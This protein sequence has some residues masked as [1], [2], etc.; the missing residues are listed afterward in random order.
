M[1]RSR[2]ICS[3]LSLSALAVRPASSQTKDALRIAYPPQDSGSEV[4][5]ANDMGF[6]D[7][8]GFDVHL[9]LLTNG[10][11]AAAGVVSG[12]MD[13]A[14]GN[15]LTVVLAYAKG[16]P[17]TIIAPGAMNDNSAAT[18]VLIVAKNSP[19][20]TA[21][22]LNGK[23]VSVSPLRAIGHVATE[24]WMD[25]NGGDSSTVHFIEIPFS[26]APAALAQGR[27]DAAFCGEPFI[28]Q[29]KSTTRY[30]ANP[31]G[32]L[33]DNFQITSFFAM[34]PWAQAHSDLVARFDAAVRMTA[35]WANKNPDKSA[36]IL[37]KNLNMDAALVRQ[38]A[39]ATFAT[40]LSPA[41]LQ[42]TI[43][44]AA[45]YKLIS[46]PFRA[47]ELLFGVKP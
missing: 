39:R 26:E 13:L 7:R 16:I 43:N 22:D 46:S 12:S 30:F 11:A 34:K 45:K 18:N 14:V 42:P 28:T 17:V 2:A 37:A 20:K 31:F 21:H 8:A 9:Q 38:T 35:E 33:G 15:V 23:I 19:L 6:F 27:V 1:K 36:D 4:L 24:Q 32:A 29:S 41:M 5:Y 3:L 25:K 10:A 47:E 44:A 40:S